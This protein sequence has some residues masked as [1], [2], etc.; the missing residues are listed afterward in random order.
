[1]KEGA[2]SVKAGEEK[3]CPL[4]SHLNGEEKTPECGRQSWK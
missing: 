3:K 4:R 2:V 1:M